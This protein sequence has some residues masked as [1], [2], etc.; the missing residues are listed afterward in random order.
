MATSGVQFPKVFV[1]TLNWNGKDDTMECVASLKKLNYPNYDIV[2]VDNG[3]TDGFVPALRARYLDVSIIENG[4]NLGYAEGFDAGLKYAY[5]HGAD[6]FLILNNDTIIDPDTLA[7]LVKG[8][9]YFAESDHRRVCRRG[10]WCCR[11]EGY[12]S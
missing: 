10:S 7:E 4:R 5:E 1:I 11:L 8:H 3:S 6:Y 2:I 9:H 12:T